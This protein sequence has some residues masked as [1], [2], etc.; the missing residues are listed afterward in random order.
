MGAI[1]YRG[2]ELVTTISEM[3][4]FKTGVALTREQMAEMIEESVETEGFFDVDNEALVRVRSEEVE[5]VVHELL[6]KLGHTS[7][8][9]R[10]HPAIALFHRYKRDPKALET[11]LSI[12]EKWAA[13]LIEAVSRAKATGDRNVDPAPFVEAMFKKHGAFG[14]KVALRLFDDLETMMVQNPWNQIRRTEWKD[15]ADLQDL[16]R[17]ESLATFYGEFFDQRFIDYL[18]RQFDAIDRINWRKF[19]GL[20]GEYFHREGFLVKLGPGRADE[21]VDARIWPKDADAG[22]RPPA[23][24][25]QCKRQRQSVPKVVVKALYA[26]VLHEKAESGLIVTTSTLSPGAKKVCSVRSYPIK[27]VD[28]VSLRTW[29]EEMRSPGTGVFL[30]E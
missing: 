1:W 4:G 26:D 20:V 16:F 22:S 10:T 24:L 11:A 27:D 15:V 2:N 8:R 3:V 13:V 28:R 29:I 18:A 9:Q 7:T 21:G 25:V 14:A 30:G 12:H 23:I 19:E 6:F 17:S 5:A